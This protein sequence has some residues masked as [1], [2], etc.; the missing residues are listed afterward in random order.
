MATSRIVPGPLNICRPINTITNG[1]AAAE[2]HW[3]RPQ[4]LVGAEYLLEIVDLS[5]VVRAAVRFSFLVQ[6]LN[7]CFIR[8]R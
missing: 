7:G 3:E 5:H 2:K 8:C 6:V 1:L 4:P